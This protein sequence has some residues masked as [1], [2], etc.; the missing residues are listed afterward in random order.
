MLISYRR[1]ILVASLF[2]PRNQMS[3]PAQN[4]GSYGILQGF[5]K[6][7]A[8]I[9]KYQSPVNLP[10]GSFVENDKLYILSV[11]CKGCVFP[12]PCINFLYDTTL[13]CFMPH[14]DF[15]LDP[16]VC[17]L[18]IKIII[19]QNNKLAFSKQNPTDG[20]FGSNL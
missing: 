15:E 18:C 11:F 2:I 19:I 10:M 9:V 6:G 16:D 13:P 8:W 17:T 7:I 1:H 12:G 5:S 14:S 20:Q 4:F 3:Q